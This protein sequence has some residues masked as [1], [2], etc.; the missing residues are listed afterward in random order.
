MSAPE[1]DRKRPES[2]RAEITAEDQT[3][4][5]PDPRPIPV[6]KLCV[7]ISASFAGDGP[8]KLCFREFNNALTRMGLLEDQ[9]SENG[10]RHK[11]P[12]PL[13]TSVGLLTKDRASDGKT[14]P[15]IL[16]SPAAQQT[17]LDRLDEIM[18]IIEQM[19]EEKNRAKRKR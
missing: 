8:E 13:G 15:V 7:R 18:E 17:I 12:T 6:T 19:R 5:L 1:P 10:K 2:F 11:I 4:L 16:Y 9:T 3:A 14:N